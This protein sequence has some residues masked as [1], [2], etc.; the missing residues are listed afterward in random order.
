[1]E[2]IK[3]IIKCSNQEV[4]YESEEFTLNEKWKEN[5]DLLLEINRTYRKAKDMELRW[6]AYGEEYTAKVEVDVLSE[7][8]SGS[9]KFA[10]AVGNLIEKYYNTKV[11]YENI[12]N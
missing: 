11:N 4:L 7:G 3:I 10:R 5:S 1:M 9:F 8:K 6:Q 12:G 2:K